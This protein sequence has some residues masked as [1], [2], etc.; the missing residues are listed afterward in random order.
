MKERLAANE[1]IVTDVIIAEESNKEK[2]VLSKGA[3][4]LLPALFKNVERLHAISTESNE[5]MDVENDEA[6]SEPAPLQPTADS[7]QRITQAIASLAGL[8]PTS[9]LQKLFKKLM[10]RLLEESQ[11]ENEV[12]D[13]LCS[14]LNLSQAL[15]AS[16]A[17]DEAS[18]M[19]LYRTMK[20]MIRSD[21]HGP[22]AQK[23]AYKVL[24]EICNCH[25]AF[26]TE[27]STM[28]ELVDLLTG[29]ALTSQVS[30]RGMRLKCMSIL[31]DGFEEGSLNDSVR[32]ILTYCDKII[33]PFLFY[34][35]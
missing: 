21:E 17:L 14:L 23:L 32:I 25:H 35:Y 24:A 29:T 5:E 16:E 10:K 15:V 3:E 19:L 28:K 34:S 26:M 18:V 20:P 30:A 2:E 4:M 11:N 8:A 27:S 7:T 33:F 1:E 22:K 12:K 13:K 31:V 6:A 9:F